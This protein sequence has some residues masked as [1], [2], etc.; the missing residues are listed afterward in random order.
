MFT[1]KLNR[2]S[3]IALSVLLIIFS[4]TISDTNIQMIEVPKVE[5]KQLAHIDP[6]Q[7]ACMARNIFFEAGNE[8]IKGQ[9]AVAHVVMNRVRH[10]FGKNPCQVIYQKTQI[11]DRI[12][13]Q[14]SWVCEN[15]PEPNKNSSRYKVAE[16]VAYDVMVNNRYQDVLP[17]TALF[18][19]NTTV[20]PLWPYKQVAII[21]G[22]IFYS[23]HKKQ[24]NTQKTVIKSDNNI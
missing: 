12:I 24:T 16:Q 18:F 3:K 8:S 10:G 9:A 1:S 19:H 7:I 5:Q 15:K 4:F 11:N 14:F 21:G 2:L 6:K 17:R 13:C 20:D 23:K 22:H